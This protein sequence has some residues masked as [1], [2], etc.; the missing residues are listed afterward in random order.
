MSARV[1]DRPC[2][3]RPVLSTRL[4][5]ASRNL[6]HCWSVTVVAHRS[7]TSRAK[8]SARVCTIANASRAG[9]RWA[10]EKRECFTL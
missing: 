9:A 5:W 2:S 4:T 6:A 1:R 3:G 8:S 10:C 7:A